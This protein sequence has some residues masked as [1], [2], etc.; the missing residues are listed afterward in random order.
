MKLKN[1][2]L[3]K[4]YGNKATVYHRTK[5]K[6][7]FKLLFSDGF[8][9]GTGAMYGNGIYTTYLPTKRIS[10][11]T[12]LYGKVQVKFAVDLIDFFIFDWTQYNKHHEHKRNVESYTKETSTKQNYIILQMRYFKVDEDTIN[13]IATK[14]NLADYAI[15]DDEHKDAGTKH[16]TSAIAIQLFLPT[17]RKTK[18]ANGIIFTGKTDGRVLVCFNPELM[19]PLSSYDDATGKTINLKDIDKDTFKQYFGKYFK[20]KNINQSNIRSKSD[21]EEIN[22]EKAE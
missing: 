10:V 19:I 17:H 18:Y 6:D 4:V 8:K 7:L 15:D 1:I 13:D 16:N 12:R 11:N 14:F 2:L 3:E 22:L 5:I 21:F 9:S 20:T